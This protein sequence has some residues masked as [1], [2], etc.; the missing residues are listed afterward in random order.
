[1]IHS[2]VMPDQH[3]LTCLFLLVG[4][5]GPALLP[6]TPSAE[7]ENHSS[8]VHTG[9]TL[10]NFNL[11]PSHSHLHHM[12]LLAED[13]SD[14]FSAGLD[15]ESNMNT[16]CMNSLTQ[17]LADNINTTLTGSQYTPYPETF[18]SYDANIS[19]NVLASP[20]YNPSLNLNGMTHDFSASTSSM[21]LV[22]DEDKDEGEEDLPSP[23]GNLLHD[24]AILDE[25]SLLDLALEEGFSPEMAARLEEEGFLHR[26]INQQ[27]TGHFDPTMAAIQ[28][29][30]GDRSSA[31]TTVRQ[32]QFYPR[33]Q[34]EGN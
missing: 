5:L 26:E 28:E 25:M 33:S 6:L 1:M 9:D 22:D 15:T 4:V 3:Q 31:R 13:P 16:F 17:D 29:Q 21:F 14:V 27:E 20:S 19:P 34:Q 10:E 8:A 23:L 32:E 7:L 11:N 18:T 2:E 12:D 30:D 24:D